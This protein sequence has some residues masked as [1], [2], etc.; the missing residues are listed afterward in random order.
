MAS[1]SADVPCEAT[2]QKEGIDKQTLIV[3]NTFIEMRTSAENPVR[4]KR[5]LSTPASAKASSLSQELVLADF[6]ERDLQRAARGRVDSSS[7]PPAMDGHKGSSDAPATSSKC[8]SESA[9]W[10]SGG[11]LSTNPLPPP[12]QPLFAAVST[13]RRLNPKARGFQ[14]SQGGLA[15]VNGVQQSCDVTTQVAFQS[16]ALVI[17]EEVKT[18]VQ[19][20]WYCQGAET[21][22]H[23]LMGGMKECRLTTLLEQEHLHHTEELVTAARGAVLAAAARSRGVSLMGFKTGQFVRSAQGFV[24][25]LGA[26]RDKSKACWYMYGKGFCN[27]AASCHWQHP[28]FVLAFRFEVSSLGTGGGGGKW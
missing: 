7:S 6:G 10:S 20:F 26:I 23:T 18:A 11:L 25:T 24:A 5:S 4:H 17:A 2:G 3:R 15:Y 1:S 16:E 22:W 27:R 9:S 21:Q 8:S 28:L 19:Q 13:H 12:P 14:P